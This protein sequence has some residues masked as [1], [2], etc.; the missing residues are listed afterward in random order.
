ML[1]FL[2]PFIL[3]GVHLTILWRHYAVSADKHT[4][5][6]KSR[7]VP[8]PPLYRFVS[9]FKWKRWINSSERCFGQPFWKLSRYIHLRA[10][11]KLGKIQGILTLSW[12]HLCKVLFTLRVLNSSKRPWNW[13]S[14]GHGMSWNLIRT[15][16]QEPWPL[17]WDCWK[18]GFT[19]SR[20]RN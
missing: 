9:K 11:C 6:V 7:N 10:H 2:S 1:L 5:F 3:Q 8:S 18:E 15:K 17:W 14:H 4:L 12:A 13:S 19:R 20:W 16:V